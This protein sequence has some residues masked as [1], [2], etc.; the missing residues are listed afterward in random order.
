LRIAIDARK[1]RDFGIGTYVRN[2]V[3]RLARLDRETTYYL[4]CKQSDEATLR[5][6][7]ENFVPVVD[8]AAGYGFRE[9]ISIPRKLRRLKADLLHRFG[10]PCVGIL[11]LEVLVGRLQLRHS[12][13]GEDDGETDPARREAV[14]RCPHVRIM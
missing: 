2:V 9:H 13:P 7:A 1:W 11:F 8:D 10:S 3:R 14:C 12:L 5:D 4:F 6:L